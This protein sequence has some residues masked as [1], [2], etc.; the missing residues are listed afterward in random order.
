MEKGKK[1]L[2]REMERLVSQR[3]AGRISL[4]GKLVAQW[5]FLPEFN[6]CGQGRKGWG[7]QGALALGQQQYGRELQSSIG[8]EGESDCEISEARGLYSSV[9]G[10]GYHVRLYGGTG[11]GPP[12]AV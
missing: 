3:R 11:N 2:R 7:E 12:S 8:R 10:G 9:R 1:E 4:G 6:L 5:G